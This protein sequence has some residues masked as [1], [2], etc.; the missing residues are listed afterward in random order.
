MKNCDNGNGIT[1]AVATFVP[2]STPCN[3]EEYDA[4][5]SLQSTPGNQTPAPYNSH[6]LAKTGSATGTADGVNGIRETF[7]YLDA[8]I[9]PPKG[10]DLVRYV[11]L[12]AGRT[13][14]VEYFHYPGEP[15]RTA[16]FDTLVKDTLRFA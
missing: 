13:Y 9:S 12:T 16:D 6:Y 8:G 11:F 3:G 7:H 14:V 4:R 10:T 15:D 2:P 5:F 1:Y